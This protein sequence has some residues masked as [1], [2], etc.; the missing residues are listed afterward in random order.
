MYGILQLIKIDWMLINFNPLANFQKN[1]TYLSKLK[2]Y[3]LN[4][5]SKFQF[6]LLVLAKKL[7]PL[8]NS[9]VDST[10]QMPI[11]IQV[12]ITWSPKFNTQNWKTC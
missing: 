4:Y 10:W 11:Q 2:T 9:Y 8:S 3:V 7:V 6:A 12:T 1:S 5:F